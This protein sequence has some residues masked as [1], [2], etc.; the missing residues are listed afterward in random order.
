M[1]LM[2]LL[3]EIESA[4]GIKPVPNA[5]TGKRGIAYEWSLYEDN[6]ATARAT[7]SLR[8]ISTTNEEVMLLSNQIK[9]ALIAF[10]DGSPVSGVT[11]AFINGQSYLPV[12]ELKQIITK[13]Q[14]YYRSE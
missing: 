8:V 4:T 5:I 7:L 6:G 1:M 9:K 11:S 2:R 3:R 10:G 13:Y 14:I 12:D